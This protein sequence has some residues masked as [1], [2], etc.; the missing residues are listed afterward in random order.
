MPQS[1]KSYNHSHTYC[2]LSPEFF[3][4]SKGFSTLMKRSENFLLLVRCLSASFHSTCTSV[5]LTVRRLVILAQASVTL[6]VALRYILNASCRSSGT[7][8]VID[9]LEA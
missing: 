4:D 8:A 3:S 1:D 6:N 2:M 7:A 9:V 5:Q